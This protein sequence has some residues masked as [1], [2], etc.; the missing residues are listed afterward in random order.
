MIHNT[1]N[2]LRLKSAY[3]FA[4]L[5]VAFFLVWLIA[6]YFDNRS[7]HATLFGRYSLAYFAFLLAVVTFPAIILSLALIGQRRLNRALFLSILAVFATGEI[8]AR[9]FF[10]QPD[11]A[12]GAHA[13]PVNYPKPYVEFTAEPGAT[14]PAKY[15]QFG[16]LPFKVSSG[17]ETLNEL[18]LRDKLPPADKAGEYR[19]ILLGGSTIWAGFP[20]SNSI[21]G[22]LESRFRR[23]GHDNV[24][25]YN[26]GVP[27]YVSGQELSLLAHSALDYDPDLII[28]YDGAND[29]Y[30]TYGGD[31]R[32]GYPF[33]W[34]LHEDGLNELRNRV[35]GG[36]PPAASLVSASRF[37]TAALTQFGNSRLDYY[38][39]DVQRLR[40]SA[41]YGTEAWAEAVADTYARNQRKMCT[42]AQGAHAKMATFLQ[43][44][45]AFKRPLVGNENSYAE[46]AEFQH[47]AADIYA[48]MRRDVEATNSFNRGGGCYS[49]DVSDIFSDYPEEIYVDLVHVTNDTNAYIASRIYDRL[50]EAG[51][52]P[53]TR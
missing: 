18:G 47:Y 49:F 7:R 16:K 5:A 30:L 51:L 26:W 33:R 10:P 13:N 41:G 6:P 32:P 24:R 48:R 35:A 37:L 28:V 22:Q 46:G 40:A 14:L 23:D 27:A 4:N 9:L 34:I 2:W 8:V 50:K 21:A 25:V 42:V 45:V 44:T 17:A 29:A 20:L 38:A 39:R 1:W 52:T 11:W 31:P 19:I 43:P 3:F 15:F 36:L 12:F 53:A